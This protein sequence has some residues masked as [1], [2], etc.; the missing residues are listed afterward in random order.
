MI[1][2]P[3]VTSVPP[4]TVPEVRA[5]LARLLGPEY[6]ETW[7]AVCQRADIA[8]E[9]ITISEPEFDALLD[10]MCERG[11]ISRVIA[12]SWKIRRTAARKLAEIGR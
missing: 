7:T 2:Q 3:T 4:P 12:M 1:E 10:A 9:A 6:D 11:S 5:S 8:P